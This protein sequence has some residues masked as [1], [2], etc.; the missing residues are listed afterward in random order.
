MGW[1]GR[2]SRGRQPG[3]TKLDAVPH[4]ELVE[5]TIGHCDVN[6]LL[7][8]DVRRLGLRILRRPT[9]IVVSMSALDMSV[10]Q[11]LALGLG[12]VGVL[13]HVAVNVL[14]LVGV[15]VVVVVFRGELAIEIVEL[16]RY[17]S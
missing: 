9:V 1:R 10:R 16:P 15:S 11:G 3:F 5:I 13:V 4:S 8:A 12:G 6:G 14:A 7:L 2:R 17:P